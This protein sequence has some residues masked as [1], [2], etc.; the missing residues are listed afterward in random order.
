VVKE[1][2]SVLLDKETMLKLQAISRK[3]NKSRTFLINEA[4]TEFVTK[5]SPKKKLGIVGIVDSGDPNFAKE[6]EKF[7]EEE[8]FGED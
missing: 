5:I 3:T 7:L 1:R 6:D 2:T 8:G 4:V